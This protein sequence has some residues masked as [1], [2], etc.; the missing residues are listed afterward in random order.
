MKLRIA[1]ALFGLFV[2][3]S[4][5]AQESAPLVRHVTPKPES[6]RLTGLA[7]VSTAESGG[8]HNREPLHKLPSFS[9]V[10]LNGKSADIA[11][12]KQSSHWLLL[13]RRENCAPCDRLQTALA[14]SDNAQ[15]K[16]GAA[17]VIVVADNGKSQN[18][19]RLDAVRAKF[20]TVTVATW[21]EDSQGAALKALKPRGTPMLYALSGDRIQ[22]GLPGLQGDPAIVEKMASAWVNSADL[23]AAQTTAAAAVNNAA[24]PAPH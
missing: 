24:T 4:A 22:W 16:G 7:S 10:Q 18:T 12:F 8:L 20:S 1:A 11:S 17:L 21:L 14:A 5:G 9:A 2:Y 23:T 15:I 19:N 6:A 13:Y 3:V